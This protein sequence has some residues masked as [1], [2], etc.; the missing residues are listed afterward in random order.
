[1]GFHTD[2]FKMALNK[3][4]FSGGLLSVALLYIT[5]GKAS[6]QSE[7]VIAGC[8]QTAI[9]LPLLKGK[10][11]AL[12]A[13]STS[14]IGKSHLADSLLSRGIKVVRIFS[15]EHGFRGDADAGSA[16]SDAV[17]SKTGMPII[18][19]YGSKTKPTQ[20]DLK[21]IDIVVYDIQ[22]VGVRFYTYISTLHYVMEVCAGNNIPIL[23][24]D[25][26]DP[27]GFY[28]DGPVLNQAFT[29][30]V[31]LHPI[32]V[33][34]GMTVGELAQMINGEGW[35]AGGL[36]CDLKVIPCINY[37][38]NT[39]YSLPVDPSPNLNSMEAVY[40]YPSLCFFE[41]TVMSLG[42]GTDFPF[43]VVGHPEYPG[44]TFSFIPQTN[45]ANKNPKYS[46]KI[47]Y[48]INLQ[49]M[50]IAG[51]RQMHELNLKWLIDVFRA[52]NC[53]DAFFSDYFDKLAGTD[54]LRKQLLEGWTE[55][56]I[57]QSWQGN[58]K[59]FRML[60]IKYLLY[61]DFDH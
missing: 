30:F 10:S 19:L 59:K 8:E 36:K 55:Q 2:L 3:A 39:C 33:V 50:D 21:G 38:H 6:T 48:G 34:Y 32:P 15:P 28:I 57:R 24:L 13:N 11:I 51:L 44:K 45:A 56:Q 42:R 9:Y 16:I 17:D 29:S 18:S 14:L 23:V 5:C 61:K 60:R 37:D 41:G 22:D 52:M 12:I 20:E 43:R 26:P 4:I 54:E 7:P 47:C 49:T 27:L 25:R 53:G 31:G 1:M 46:G 35:L 58:L 40:L